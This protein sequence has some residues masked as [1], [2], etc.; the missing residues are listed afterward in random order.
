MH[1]LKSTERN[2][3]SGLASRSTNAAL[4]HWYGILCKV[5]IPYNSEVVGES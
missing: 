5:V 2:D 3:L 1:K 4:V